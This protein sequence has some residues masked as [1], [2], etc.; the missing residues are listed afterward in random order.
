MKIFTITLAYNQPWIIEQSIKQYYLKNGIKPDKHFF[1]NNH[2]PLIDRSK[3]ERFLKHLSHQYNLE[4]IDF[5][6]NMGME[7]SL[8]EFENPLQSLGRYVSEDDLIILYDCNNFVLTQNFDLQMFEFYKQKIFLDNS[9][10]VGLS[11]EY[12][13]FDNYYEKKNI[14]YYLQE[15]NNDLNQFEKWVCGTVMMHKQHARDYVINDDKRY[16]RDPYLNKKPDHKVYIL[17]DCKE[18]I[19]YFYTMED[20]EYNLYKMCSHFLKINQTFES[21][22]L[23][24]DLKELKEKLLNHESYEKIKNK[25]VIIY[26]KI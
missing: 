10:A 9:I 24:K 21:F 23:R 26:D 4:Y 12:T 13:E 20:H 5:G 18:Y 17:K 1:V 11:N 3:N 15:K 25:K 6:E 8:N 19:N 16:Y 22:I 14:K 7:K 2:Y